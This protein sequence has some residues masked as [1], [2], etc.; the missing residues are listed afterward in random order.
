MEEFDRR[1]DDG[2]DIRDLIDISKA[3]IIRHGRKVRITIDEAL[4]IGAQF[5]PIKIQRIFNN[6][7]ADGNKTTQAT[8]IPAFLYSELQR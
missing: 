2:E 6:P 3:K 4:E 7:D 1:F 5:P 8:T